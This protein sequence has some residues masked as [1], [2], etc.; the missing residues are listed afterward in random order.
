MSEN[1]GVLAESEEH[2]ERCRAAERRE[3]AKQAVRFLGHEPKFNNRKATD[4]GEY[5]G[6]KPERTETRLYGQGNAQVRD[7]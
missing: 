7:C 4:C 3:P 6:R 1:V 2:G 5:K